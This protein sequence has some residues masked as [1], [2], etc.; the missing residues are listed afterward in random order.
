[1]QKWVCVIAFNWIFIMKELQIEVNEMY[2]GGK[3]V[4]CKVIGDL[5]ESTTW[6]CTNYS[7]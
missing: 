5:T 3:G 6:G 2:F 7:N 4:F 1:M